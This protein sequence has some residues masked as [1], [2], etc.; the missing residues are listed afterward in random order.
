MKLLTLAFLACL[1]TSNSCAKIGC[2]DNSFHAYLCNDGNECCGP[3]YKALH[4]VK[5]ACPCD[6]YGYLEKQGRCMHCNHFRMPENFGP[7]IESYE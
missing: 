5:C 1:L 6:S 3:D 4:Y 7:I 2:M